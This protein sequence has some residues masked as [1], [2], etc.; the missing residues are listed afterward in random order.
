MFLLT[1]WCGDE[2]EQF[3]TAISG[4]ATRATAAAAGEGGLGRRREQR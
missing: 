4:K 3:H 2:S 1:D